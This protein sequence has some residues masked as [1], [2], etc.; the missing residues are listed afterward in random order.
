MK[1]YGGIIV[2]LFV[3]LINL[4]VVQAACTTEEMNKLN[5]LAVRVTADTDV[6]ELE[7]PMEEG[8]NPPDGLTDEE[9]ENYLKE[10]T[11][12]RIYISNITEELYVK[13]TDTQSEETKTYTYQDAKDGVITIDQEE[14]TSTNNYTIEVYSSDKTN[15]PDSKLYTLYETTPLYNYYSEQALCEGIEDFYLCHEFLSVPLVSYDEFVTLAERY[16]EGM[17]N[18][19]GEE[20]TPDEDKKEEKG[21]AKFLKDNRNII[22]VV[23]IVVVAVGGL[24]TVI[25]VK[26][27]RSR[28]V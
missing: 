20:V 2:A 14:I 18:E 27:Q 7:M 22:I 5:S 13:V 25:I 4:S 12:F 28:I 8:D 19:N 15:C 23:S 1:K 11:I 24:V 6:V 26:K 17:V 9:L 16:R 3:F 21:F 10:E